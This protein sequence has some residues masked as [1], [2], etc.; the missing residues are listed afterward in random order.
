MVAQ[1]EVALAAGPDS[2][3]IVSVPLGGGRVRFN[4]ALVHRLGV[5][6]PLNNHVGIFEPLLYIAQPKLKVVGDVG[7]FRGVSPT[8]RPLCRIG[9]S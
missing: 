4:V 8:A 6:L 9:Q 5:E 3:G 7:G 2:N 1:G